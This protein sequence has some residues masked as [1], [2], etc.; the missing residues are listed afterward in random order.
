[1]PL[2]KGNSCDELVPAISIQAVSMPFHADRRP[3]ARPAIRIDS[4]ARTARQT[5]VSHEPLV[6]WPP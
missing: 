6:A 2:D 1:M 4:C 5:H 3:A